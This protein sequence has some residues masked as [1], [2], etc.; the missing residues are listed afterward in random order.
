M[1]AVIAIFISC[2]RRSAASAWRN[3]LYFVWLS[4]VGCFGGYTP[5]QAARACDF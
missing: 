1:G 5:R 2:A 4:W 3:F